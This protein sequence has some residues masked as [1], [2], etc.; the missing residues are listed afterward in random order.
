MRLCM[1][2]LLAIV[3]LGLGGKVQAVEPLSTAEF[4]SHCVKFHD[5]DAE[6]DRIFCV[7]YIQGF[8]DGAIA[9]DE[10]VTYNVAREFEERESFSQR[11]TR[12]RIGNRL[13]RFGSSVYAEFCLGDPVPLLEVVERVVQ[14]TL[15]NTLVASTPL[16]R[17]LVY[18]TLRTHYACNE[19][20]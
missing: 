5:P 12:T 18:L 17:D 11:A 19:S 13:E 9:T 2:L 8:I 16:A 14:D 4:A 1:L 3:G 7:R 20:D 10:R 6:E 15:N